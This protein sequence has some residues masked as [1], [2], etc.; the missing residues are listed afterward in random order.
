MRRAFSAAIDHTALAQAAYKGGYTPALTISQPG[1]G[2]YEPPQPLSPGPEAAHAL[3]AAAGYPSGRGFPKVTYLY[4]TADR[5]RM[6]AEILQQMW[7]SELGVEVELVNQEWKVFLDT[8]RNR[9][10][11]I[12]R[13]GWFPFANEPTDYFGL[14]LTDSS[15]NDTGWGDACFDALYALSLQT[16]DLDARHQLYRQMDSILFAQ[17]PAAPLVHNS[18]VH[19]VHPSVRNWP[20]NVMDARSLSAVYLVGEAPYSA[21]SSSANSSRRRAMNSRCLRPSVSPP[22]PCGLSGENRPTS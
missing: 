18:T 3:L 12:A 7:R 14:F 19:L 4:N 20:N 13:S 6:V 5:N 11:A 16:V 15:Y 10:F 1:M 9:D 8:R 2:G 22:C 17:A 21:W